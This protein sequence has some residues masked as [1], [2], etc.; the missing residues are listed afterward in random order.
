MGE[1]LVGVAEKPLV[2]LAGEPE[3]SQ[4]LVLV[5][6]QLAAVVVALQQAGKMLAQFSPV[7]LV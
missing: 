6:L 7:L 5:E 1:L 4:P 2:E 3:D